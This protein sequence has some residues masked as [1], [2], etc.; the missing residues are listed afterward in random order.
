MAVTGRKPSDGPKMNHVAPVHDWREVANLPYRGKKPPL[1]K[2]MPPETRAWWR[3]ITSLPH[4]IFWHA[5]EWRFA[6]DTARVHAAFIGGDMA[7]AAELRLR[8]RAMGTTADARRDLRIR[9]VDPYDPE[10]AGEPAATSTP[11]VDLAAE[12]R[13]RLTDAS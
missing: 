11:A 6:I 8:E 3:D 12:R 9:Y 2:S 7:R 5:G 10:Q 1:P 13:R 4:C